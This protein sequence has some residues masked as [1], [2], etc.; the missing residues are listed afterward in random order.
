LED[1]PVTCVGS[2]SLTCASTR[3]PEDVVACVGAVDAARVATAEAGGGADLREVGVGWGPRAAVI[4][5]AVRVDG[6]NVGLEGGV[7]NRRTGREARVCGVWGMALALVVSG[8]AAGAFLG[9]L[10]VALMSS[11]GDVISGDSGDRRDLRRRKSSSGWYTGGPKRG[12][13]QPFSAEYAREYS[14]LSRSRRSRASVSS[15]I[16]SRLRRSACSSSSSKR[17][18][19]G[20]VVFPSDNFPSQGC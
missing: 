10:R 17:I 11:G 14:A 18:P 13:L 3:R 12:C 20:S 16:D 8:L 2:I 15:L 4:G 9:S 6:L 5:K 1:S 19:T 7:V